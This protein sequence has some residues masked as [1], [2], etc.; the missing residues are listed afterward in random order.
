MEEVKDAV[1]A[2]NVDFQRR[3]VRFPVETSASG[4]GVSSN[5]NEL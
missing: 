4:G 1:H 5:V 3:I 2:Y